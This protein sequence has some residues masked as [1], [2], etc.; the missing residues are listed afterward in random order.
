MKPRSYLGVAM[1]TT[2]FILCTA[3][4]ADKGSSLTRKTSHPAKQ[5]ATYYYWYYAD[6]TYDGYFTESQVIV[7]LEDSL[8]QFVNSSP[9][10]GTFVAAGY[11]NNDYPHDQHPLVD[12]YSH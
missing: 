11:F 8:Q 9:F 4:S 6:D 10:G 7:Q 2:I 12:L 1:A 3:F 5:F